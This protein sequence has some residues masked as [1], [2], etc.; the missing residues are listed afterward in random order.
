MKNYELLFILPGTL[1]EDEVKPLVEKIKTIVTENGG[2]NLV[3]KDLGKNRLAYPIR[4]IRYGYF[5]LCRF[6]AEVDKIDEIKNKLSLMS[7]PLRVLIQSF[8]PEEQKEIKLEHF[9]TAENARAPREEEKPRRH[10]DAS[11]EQVPVS[12]KPKEIKDSAPKKKVTLEEIDKQLDEI[13][14]N[15]ISDV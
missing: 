1:T 13:L 5:N 11:L 14:D 2:E 12:K 3:M 8:N 6:E 10:Q 7:E 9:T 15:E 4:H